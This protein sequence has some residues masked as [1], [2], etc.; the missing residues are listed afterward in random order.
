MCVDLRRHLELKF[1]MCLILQGRRATAARGKTVAV[2]HM[3]PSMYCWSTWRPTPGVRSESAQ[4]SS[5]FLVLKTPTLLVEFPQIQKRI[6]LKRGLQ[7]FAVCVLILCPTAGDYHWQRDCTGI[8]GFFLKMRMFLWIPTL[9][10]PL[11]VKTRFGECLVAVLWFV[12]AVAVVSPYPNCIN[13][14]LSP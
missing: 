14:A 2:M 12:F 13:S 3:S 11:T 9:L 5:G 1:L 7:W 6:V 8:S 4:P 10:R